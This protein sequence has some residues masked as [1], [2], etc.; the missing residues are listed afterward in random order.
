MD[1]TYFMFAGSYKMKCKALKKKPDTPRI[2]IAWS[3]NPEINTYLMCVFSWYHKCVQLQQ[4]EGFKHCTD[5]TK[6]FD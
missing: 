3:L 2:S 6:S 4:S 1:R 5:N